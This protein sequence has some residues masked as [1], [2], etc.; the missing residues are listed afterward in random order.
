MNYTKEMNLLSDSGFCMPFD[1]QNGEVDLILA[2]GEQKHP[3]NGESFFHHGVDFKTH[4]YLLS[5]LADGKV[6]GIGNDMRHGL[7][8]IIQYGKYTVKY[9]H[10]SSANVLFGQQVKAGAMVGISGELLHMEVH[11]AE[12]EINPIDFITMLYSNLKTSNMS[13]CPGGPIEFITLDMDV[14]TEYDHC[15]EEVEQL[16][17]RYYPSYMEELRRGS[18]AVSEHTQQSLRNIFTVAAMKNYF[19]EVIP[20]LANPLGVGKKATPVAAKVQ[21]L[22]ISDFLNYL[23]VR[24]HIFLSGLSENEKKK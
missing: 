3:A 21:N 4:Y 7:Y 13:A 20:S 5:A 24:Q 22:L 15:K 14:V 23:A 18:Y 1:D 12:E 19:F 11:Y 2:Y 9:G 10:M 6:T 8:L 16:M 17:L